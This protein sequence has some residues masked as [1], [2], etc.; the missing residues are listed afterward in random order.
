[1]IEGRD[2]VRAKNESGEFF[3]TDLSSIALAT[4]ECGVDGEG[5]EETLNAEG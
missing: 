2:A 3:L 4:E 5:I 1:M